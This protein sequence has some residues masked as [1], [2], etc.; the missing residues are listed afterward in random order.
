VEV[1]KGTPGILS[2]K[3]KTDDNAEAFSE[4]RYGKPEEKRMIWLINQRPLGSIEAVVGW[5]LK[6][7][8]KEKGKTRK[9]P[10][11]KA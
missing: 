4:I 7:R 1:T 5:R 10:I 3:N 11:H 6:K 9:R 2:K 8:F